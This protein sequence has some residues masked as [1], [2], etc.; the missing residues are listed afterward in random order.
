MISLE[1]RK[2]ALL[3]RT[4]LLKNELKY[5]QQEKHDDTSIETKVY[6]GFFEIVSSIDDEEE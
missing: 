5:L 1:E 3:I 2:L 6:P 4:K